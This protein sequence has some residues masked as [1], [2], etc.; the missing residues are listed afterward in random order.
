MGIL[1]YFINHDKKEWFCPIAKMSEIY[2]NRTMM[3]GILNILK[4]E[5]N[6]NRIE[7]LGELNRKMMKVFED[8]KEK[9]VDWDL[10]SDY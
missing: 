5:W 7:I 2:I 9:K 6:N 10:Y 3:C 8:Y 4:N 1:V